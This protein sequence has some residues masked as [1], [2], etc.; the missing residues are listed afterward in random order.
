VT[1][2]SLALLL[3]SIAG[4]LAALQP[5]SDT[6]MWWHLATGRE[7]L[8]SGFVRTDI[9]SWTIP[10]APVTTD[11][12]LGQILM[13]LSYLA[14]GWR[15]IAILRVLLVTALVALTAWSAAGRTARP[16]AI[17]LATLPAMFLTRAIAVDRPEL[18]GFVCFA[19]LLVLVRSARAGHRAA[20]VAIVLLMGIWT[21][22]HGSFALGAVVT[23]IAC[24]EG[25]LSDALLRRDYLVC[26]V[27]ALA[28]TLVDPAGLGSWTAPGIHLLSPPRAIQEWNVIDV[29]TPLGLTYA[30]TLAL[31][32]ARVFLGPRV[33]RSELVVLV[34][35]AFLSLTA[36]RQAPLLGIAAAPLLAEGVHLLLRRL[37]ASA[38]TRRAATL[39]G[40][41]SAIV[42]V[43]ALFATPIAPEISAYPVAALSS[44]PTG[45]GVLARYEWGGWLIWSGIPVFVDGRLTPYRGAV[46]DDYSR[47]LAAAP[48][49]RDVIARRG[50]RMLLVAPSD[51]VAVRASELGWSVR[52]RSN[53]VIL[54]AVP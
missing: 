29:R 33:P 40:A 46:L 42:L 28:V 18:L 14:A 4:L 7:T 36:A 16:L 43:V 30:A 47:V 51:P 1:R 49:W 48:G 37:P 44:I 54:I 9:F 13:Y 35:I 25:A 26:A 24:V 52:T 31:V 5:I 8:A 32:I 27:A 41:G 50:V 20:L 6:D 2:A 34:P 45:D 10:G 19:A 38:S 11:Q 12:W 39:V 23:V 17:V 15:G 3:G 53:N 22:V 21:N